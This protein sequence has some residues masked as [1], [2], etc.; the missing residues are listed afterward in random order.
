MIQRFHQLTNPHEDQDQ[1]CVQHLLSSL[2]NEGD[3]QLLLQN[4]NRSEPDAAP[5]QQDDETIACLEQRLNELGIDVEEVKQT[6]PQFYAM[7][8][9]LYQVN[10][11]RLQ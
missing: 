7:I 3:Q 10:L 6:Q 11:G 9:L 8:K 1:F 4:L 2:A 5:E